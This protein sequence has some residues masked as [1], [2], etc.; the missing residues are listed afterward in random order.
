M[1]DTQDPR[2]YSFKVPGLPIELDGKRLK[3]RR[4]P[5][6][7]G[8]GGREILLGLGYSATEIERLGA[9]RIVALA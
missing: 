4:A 6:A 8:E 7:L 9:E 3:Q 5:P 2:G 1:I